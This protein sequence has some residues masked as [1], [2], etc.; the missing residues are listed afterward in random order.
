MEDEDVI[1]SV[2]AIK[3]IEDIGRQL[4][5]L[6]EIT[7]GM[8]CVVIHPNGNKEKIHPI[9]DA[10]DTLDMCRNALLSKYGKMMWESSD[11]PINKSHSEKHI[12]TVPPEIL[13]QIF[14]TARAQAY[15]QALE[16]GRSVQLGTGEV[17]HGRCKR[18][19]RR[20]LGP[21]SSGEV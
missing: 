20:L 18:I 13:S 3:M 5:A 10:I 6:Q 12:L 16:D 8:L 14:E 4:E 7:P 2:A 11:G 15:K 1:D 21:P 9:E 17:E 19:L